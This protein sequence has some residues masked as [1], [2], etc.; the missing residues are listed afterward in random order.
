MRIL[1][2]NHTH[3]FALGTYPPEK[4][5]FCT[6]RGDGITQFKVK[7]ARRFTTWSIENRFYTHANIGVPCDAL[8]CNA[9]YF[10]QQGDHFDEGA[11]TFIGRV[12]GPLIKGSYSSDTAQ[13]PEFGYYEY[14]VF[15]NAKTFAYMYFAKMQKHADQKYWGLSPFQNEKAHEACKDFSK[16]YYESIFTRFAQPY[17]VS[18]IKS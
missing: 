17:P 9:L 3:V 1:L 2:R 7:G 8:V 16:T 5:E 4:V 10:F 12:H 11:Y 13:E 6:Y 14:D 18:L 15:Q